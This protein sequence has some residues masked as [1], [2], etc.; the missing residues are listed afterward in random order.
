MATVTFDILEWANRLKA[1][2]F[3]SERADAV[4]RVIADSHD[5]LVT[6]RDLQIELAPVRTDLTLLKWM[7]GMFPQNRRKY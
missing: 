5:E 3:Q 6:T 1:A 2:G 7:M 4:V